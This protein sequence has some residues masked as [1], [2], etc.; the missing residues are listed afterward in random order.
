MSL[1]GS[2]RR[3]R[4]RQTCRAQPMG[5]TAVALSPLHACPPR[6]PHPQ[7]RCRPPNPTALPPTR[8]CF[9]PPPHRYGPG[10][11]KK[12]GP[13]PSNN[14]RARP[15][16]WP[17]ANLAQAQ[18]ATPRPPCRSRNSK[19][20]N[21]Q[22][23]TGR[24]Q[25]EWAR[26][27][28]VWHR[29]RA[30]HPPGG[31]P[32]LA[33]AALAT[34]S[35]PLAR[36]LSGSWRSGARSTHGRGACCW[37]NFDRRNAGSNFDRRNAGPKADWTDDPS[38]HRREDPESRWSGR[39]HRSKRRVCKRANPQPISE[40]ISPASPCC[41]PPAPPLLQPCHPPRPAAPAEPP[42]LPPA[43]QPPPGGE[44]AR[45]RPPA[46]RAPA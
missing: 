12:S 9:C 41:P 5:L 35:Q 14:R 22:A 15:P 24:R 45:G 17:C 32:S 28:L 38:G 19:A 8:H 40:P 16:R 11:P 2:I 21:S 46:L 39:P 30:G 36:Q 37:S 27:R 10:G 23:P 42:P 29:W 31:A 18:W 13:R 3:P 34:G 20:P 26:R 25:P 7:P 4:F 43:A 1:A 33:A 44:A 6:A